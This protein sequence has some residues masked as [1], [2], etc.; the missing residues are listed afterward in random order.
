[1][2][3]TLFTK[4]ICAIITSIAVVGAGWFT[5]PEMASAAESPP[6]P[7]TA[8]AD[9]LPT[10]QIDNGVIWANKIVGDIA[11]VGGDFSNARPAGAAAGTNLTPRSNFLAFNIRTGVLVPSIAPSFNGLVYDIDASPDGT[12]LYVVGTFTQVNGQTRNRIAVLDLPSGNLNSTV[13]PN[14]NGVTQSVAATNDTIYVGGYFGAVNNTARARVAAI[15]ASNG[16]LLPF[17]PVVDDGM[18]QALTVNPGGTSV[19]MGGNFTSVEGGSANPGYGLSRVDGIT[20]AQLSLPLN[21]TVRNAGPNSGVTRLATDGTNF[22]GVGWH[23]GPGGNME[24]AFSANWSDGTLKWIEDCHGDTYDIAPSGDVVYMASHKHYCGN[25]GGFPQD[26]PWTYHHS[27]AV[28]KAVGGVNT[29]DI[30]GYPDHPGEPRPDI[31]NWY[32]QTDIGTYTGQ[33]QAVW[34][35]DATE[36]YVVY[37]G[38]F[39]RVN[40][41]AQY[42]LVRYA[43]RAKA[44]NKQG[45]RY[46]GNASSWV[47]SAVSAASGSVR[48]S[49]KTVWDRDDRDLTYRL[50]RDT[51]DAAGLI[52]EQTQ[53]SLYWQPKSVRVIDDSL[54]PGSTH[55]YRVTAFDPW[56]NNIRSNWVTV[57]VSDTVMSPYASLVYQDDAQSYWRLGDQ[58]GTTA[59]DWLG[60]TDL[61]LQGGAT[62]GATGAI[63]G[64]ADAATTFSNGFGAASTTVEGPSSFAA[65]AWIRTTTGSG[66]KIIGFGNA[67]TGDSTSYDRHVYMDNA[68][69]IWFGVY[70]NAVKVINSP[71]SYNDGQWHHIVASLGGEGMRLYVDGKRVAQNATVTTGQAYSGN[72]RIAGDNLGGWPNRPSS[73]YFSGDIDDVAVYAAPLPISKVQAHYSASGRTLVAPPVPSDAYGALIRQADPEIYWRYDEPS[74]DTLADTGL[75]TVPGQLAGDYLRNQPGALA[76]GIGK[77]VTFHQN[78]GNAFSTVNFSAPGTYSL[79]TWFNTTSLSGGKLIGLGDAQTGTSSNYD[80]HV[81]MQDDGRLVFGTWTGQTNTITTTAA[82]N[83]GA[84]HHMVATQDANGMN[85][86]VDGMSTGSNPQT[87]AQ[88]FIGYWRVGGD[89]TWGS[90][91]PNLIGSFDE[92]AIYGRA[93]TAQEAASHFAVGSDVPVPNILPLPVFT[94]AVTGLAV[95]VDGA[96]SSDP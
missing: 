73:D 25:S 88:D 48:V 37:G 62:R 3:T 11:Y 83:D 95:S 6:E 80:R 51:E 87:G 85:L 13:V 79:E 46:L 28:T 17:R 90:S 33:S 71:S 5:F 22:Y 72:W 15:R 81:Y 57:T 27:T 30:Y 43:V 42:G 35:V 31:L 44:P 94:T 78:G 93:L 40:G 52:N 60:T 66:G 76:G 2:S 75:Q 36:E 7:L 38:E 64:D 91:S 21:N 61:T 84:W 55:R 9:A 65:E 20:G 92:T 45:P 53:T 82:F 26:N 89:T 19:V 32:P 49:Y 70:P 77:A 68:G 12:K 23:Y 96:G 24:G 4:R 67:S 54:A 1:M 10:V 50:Y 18:V 29:P 56:G 86:Y 16:S 39:P 69:K 74:G 8:S 41:T 59:V 58:D 47:P 63:I 34:R 14:I